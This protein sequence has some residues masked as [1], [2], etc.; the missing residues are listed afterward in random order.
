MMTTM[1][2]CFV[3]IISLLSIGL[4]RSQ[5]GIN[6]KSPQGMFHVDP[7]SNTNGAMNTSDDVV[8]NSAGNLGLGTVNPQAKIHIKSGDKSAPNVGFALQDGSQGITRV[9]MSDANGNASWRDSRITGVAIG[10]FGSGVAIS[11][12][13]S[14]SGTVGGNVVVARPG[15]TFVKTSGQIVLT[16]GTWWVKVAMYFSIL[17]NAYEYQSWIRTSIADDASIGATSPS[18][19]Y[20][21]DLRSSY[22]LASNLLWQNSSAGVV[23]G[24]FLIDNMSNSPKTYYLVVGWTQ[25]YLGTAANTVFKTGSSGNAENAIIAYRIN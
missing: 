20:S 4:C 3:L 13:I 10:T 17:A 18:L 12:D 22:S 1:K 24:S 11:L 9:L 8:V 15:N 7:K 6:T 21:A 25:P 16:K 2:K 19:Q 23:Y 5:V 14:Y